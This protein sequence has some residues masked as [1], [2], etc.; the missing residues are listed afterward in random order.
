MHCKVPLKKAYCYISKLS[1]KRNDPYILFTAIKDAYEDDKPNI[2]LKLQ[3]RLAKICLNDDD[4]LNAYL[5]ELPL[6]FEELIHLDA[7]IYEQ[8][9]V[10]QLLKGLGPKYYQFKCHVRVYQWNNAN[11]I[12][13]SRN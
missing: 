10:M 6:I 4:N 1:D 5:Q 8:G 9:K 3:E 13:W 11:T 12:K 7:G 2:L